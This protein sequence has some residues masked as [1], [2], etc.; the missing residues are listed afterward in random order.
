M[1]LISLP[2]KTR[3]A[4]NFSSRKDSKPALRLL[5]TTFTL[6]VIHLYYHI[7]YHPH[8]RIAITEEKRRM[9]NKISELKSPIWAA[10]AGPPSDQIR[11]ARLRMMLYQARWGGR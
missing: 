11:I 4:S 8:V 6:S 7:Q 5:A 9:T 2:C 3:P 10:M 1:D